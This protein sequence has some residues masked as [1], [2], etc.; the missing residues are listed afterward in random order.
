MVLYSPMGLTHMGDTKEVIL[1]NVMCYS[2]RA[3]I[4]DLL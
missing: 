3:A 2:L 1:I 4:L